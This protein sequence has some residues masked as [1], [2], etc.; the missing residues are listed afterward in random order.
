MSGGLPRPQIRVLRAP[1]SILRTTHCSSFRTWKG[2]H[3][4]AN[5]HVFVLAKGIEETRIV[6]FATRLIGLIMVATLAS[7][8]SA[9]DQFSA[10]P[11]GLALPP[12]AMAPAG[13]GEELPPMNMPEA[14]MNGSNAGPSSVLAG[15][16]QVAD[17]QETPEAACPESQPYDMWGTHPAIPVSSGSW[18]DRGLWYA[19]ADGIVADRV[20]SKRDKFLVSQD[21]NVNNLVFFRSLVLGGGGGVASLTTNRNIFLKRA[22]PGAD[23]A[24]NVTLGRFLFRDDDNRDHSLEFTAEGGGDWNQ[25][26]VLTSSTPFNLFVPI[27]TDGGNRSFDSNTTTA[28][29]GSS[30]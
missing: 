14:S 24:A 16:P 9:D 11:D 23:A 28:G 20:W 27:I 22:H 5:R 3:E 12:E 10:D 15:P 13:A 8:A 17:E 19:E 18:L 6:N 21:P 29:T 1:Q 4:R 30:R 7:I 2:R 26:M 25:D